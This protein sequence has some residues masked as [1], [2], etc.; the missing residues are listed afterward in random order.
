MLNVTQFRVI[1]FITLW[2]DVLARQTRIGPQSK[3]EEGGGTNV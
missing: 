3:Q 1:A 2:L